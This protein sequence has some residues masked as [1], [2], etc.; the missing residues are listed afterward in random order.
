[1]PFPFILAAVAVAGAASAASQANAGNKA[2]RST[3]KQAT[4]ANAANKALRKIET[5]DQ[6]GKLAKTFGRFSGSARVSASDRNASGRSADLIEQ[7]GLAA[8][9]DDQLNLIFSMYTQNIAGDSDTSG[10]IQRSNASMTSPGLAGISG[11]LSGLMLGA[12]LNS[13]F[14]ASK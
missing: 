4:A 8:S 9:L 5:D 1:M 14:K 10:I 7:T 11:G 2:A 6:I 13:A 3:S 12:N